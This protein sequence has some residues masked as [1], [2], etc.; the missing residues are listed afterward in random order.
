MYSVLEML[1]RVGLL[2]LLFGSSCSL[3]FSGYLSYQLLNEEKNS[4]SPTIIV[5]S[6]IFPFNYIRFC[7]IYFDELLF[8][9]LSVCI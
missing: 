6:S 3:Q 8:Y 4:K 7:F 2:I 1:V 9:K 5:D